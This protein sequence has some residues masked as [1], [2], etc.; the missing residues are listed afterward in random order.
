ME[1]TKVAD[2]SAVVATQ[3]ELLFQKRCCHGANYIHTH[4]TQC[5][6][7]LG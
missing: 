5:E 1:L 6:T 3:L 4:A 7:L 2:L